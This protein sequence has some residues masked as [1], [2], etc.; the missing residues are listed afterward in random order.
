MSAGGKAYRLCCCFFQA[1]DGIRDLTVT[2]VQTCALPISLRVSVAEKLRPEE[3]QDVRTFIERYGRDLFHARFMTLANLRG[4]LRGGIQAFLDFLRENPDPLQ[5]IRLI[6]D[7]EAQGTK[8]GGLDVVR[9]LQ[10][11]LEILVE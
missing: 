9:L 2:G 6:D 1:E 5:P 8:P 4:I 7:I 10:C 3:W 11:I